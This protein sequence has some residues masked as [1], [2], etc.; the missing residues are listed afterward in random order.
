MTDKR[1]DPETER[2]LID[3]M[4]QN[5]PASVYWYAKAYADLWEAEDAAMVSIDKE[6]MDLNVEMPDGEQRIR[7]VF[8]HPLADDDD[9]QSTLVEMSMHAREIIMTRSQNKRQEVE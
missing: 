5:H 1:F 8:D 3:Y 9:A 2:Y 6:G 7:I 4:N